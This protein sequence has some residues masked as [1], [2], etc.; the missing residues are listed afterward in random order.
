MARYGQAETYCRCPDAAALESLGIDVQTSLFGD[1]L[2][3]DCAKIGPRRS[4]QYQADQNHQADHRQ[5]ESDRERQF[6]PHVSIVLC[7][8]RSVYDSDA[9]CRIP[10]GV[11]GGLAHQMPCLRR[12]RNEGP[13]RVAPRSWMRFEG[14]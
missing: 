12:R 6:G 2:P 13:A 3:A 7:R 14:L 8:E 1:P 4:T 9:V 5:A 11:D 10:A